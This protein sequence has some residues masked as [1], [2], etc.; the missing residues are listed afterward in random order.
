MQQRN[1]IIQKR[2]ITIKNINVQFTIKFSKNKLC[3]C[4]R[5]TMLSGQWSIY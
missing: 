4:N 1:I 5:K 3:C 2:T